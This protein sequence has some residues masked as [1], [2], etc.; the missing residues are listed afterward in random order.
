MN[1]SQKIEYNVDI[2]K[3]CSQCGGKM[4]LGKKKI[5]RYNKETGKTES[6]K[7]TA[8]CENICGWKAILN[9]LK[10]HDAFLVIDTPYNY[11][12]KEPHRTILAVY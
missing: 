8:K 2:S 10:V 1:K 11:T 7:Y 3:F 4:I 9:Y 5:N 6:Y 12:T